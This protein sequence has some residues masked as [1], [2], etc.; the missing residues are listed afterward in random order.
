MIDELKGTFWGKLNILSP[1]STFC[2]VVFMFLFWYTPIQ[3]V[4]L[5]FNLQI[6][7]K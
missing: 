2:N 6:L 5:N 3:T 4:I 1:R 7:N